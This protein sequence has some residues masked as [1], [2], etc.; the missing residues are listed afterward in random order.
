MLSRLRGYAGWSV[1]LL[2][3]NTEDGGC[4]LRASFF[5]PTPIIY[6]VFE[7]NDIFIFLIEQNVYI[8]IYCSLIFIPYL[9]SEKGAIWAAHPYYVIY[10]ELPSPHHPPPPTRGVC[11]G[12]SEPL[13]VAHTTLNSLNE[14]GGG[15]GGRDKILGYASIFS[16]Y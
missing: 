10:R 2:F 16:L 8:F 12:W 7:K 1:P 11:A 15:G 4:N 6:L 13:L 3:E 9:L 5:K 14:L